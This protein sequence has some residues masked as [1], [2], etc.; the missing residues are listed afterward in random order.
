MSFSG[1][2]STKPAINPAEVKIFLDPPTQFEDMG[3]F[4]TT[5]WGFLLGSLSGRK[6]QN[7][8][9]NDLKSRAGGM[10]ANAILLHTKSRS[11]RSITVEAS[12]IYVIQE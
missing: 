1:S 5:R 9:M 12:V 2:A 11:S 6:T 8:I 10:G 3:R 7:E 4:K